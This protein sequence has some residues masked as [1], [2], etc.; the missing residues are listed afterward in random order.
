MPSYSHERF[1][2]EAIEGVLNQS[3][4]DI[5]LIIVDDASEDNSKEI[6]KSYREK[7]RR[8]RAIFHDENRGI[9]KTFNDG[10]EEASGKFI[11]VTGSDDVWFKD[12]LEKQLEMLKKNEDLVVYS[13][14]LVIDAQSNLVEKLPARKR[15]ASKKKKS[16]KIF[17]E[18]LGGNFIC[19]SSMIFKK[20]NI[21]DIRFDEQFKYVNDYKFVLELA[22]K[23]EYYFIPEP[24]VKYRIHGKNCTLHDGTGWLNDFALI[25]KYLLDK[26]ENELPTKVKAKFLFSIGCDACS[27]G[28]SG[29]GRKYIL[30]AIMTY[31]FRI[32][33][34]RS[35]M[36]SFGRDS[37]MPK[38]LTRRILS[39]HKQ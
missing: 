8:I 5:E 3:C 11:A 21:K 18:L 25:G 6:I 13:D 23:Y 29:N 14:S 28:D 16:G 19:G 1:I 33:Y 39:E 31:P 38:S 24:L 20:D 32:E 30:K 22:I 17:R 4:Q 26:Y 34:L 2:S 9:A 12:K 15:N 7:D 35:L 36:L 37:I 27:R 10:I